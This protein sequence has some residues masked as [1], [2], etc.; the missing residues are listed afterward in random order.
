MA[1]QAVLIINKI[2]LDW[3]RK[4]F[5]ED[6]IFLARY[7]CL[8]NENIH[9]FCC[10]KEF[11][12]ELKHLSFLAIHWH[13]NRQGHDLLFT[14][15]IS[16]GPVITRRVIVLFGIY[17][18]IYN[19]IK[20]WL[21]KV[22]FLYVSLDETKAFC[23]VAKVFGHRIRW[24]SSSAIN[25]KAKNVVLKKPFSAED[26]PWL[27]LD[28]LP[29]IHP[30]SKIARLAQ[31]FFLPLARR[32]KHLYL[33]DWTS[34]DLAKKRKDTL[35]LN[36]KLPWKA[37]YFNNPKKFQKEGERV[38][39]KEVL[40]PCVNVQHIREVLSRKNIQW[41]EQLI[42]FFMSFVET[43]Y[44]DNR[45]IIIKAYSMYKDLIETYKPK[46][47]SI[48]GG[49]QFA[50]VIACQIARQSGAQTLL[51]IDGYQPVDD[52]SV[53]YLDET[54]KNFLW[55]DFAAYGQANLELLVSQG[56]DKNRC[57]LMEPTIINIHKRLKPQPKKYEAIVMGY[58]PYTINPQSHQTPERFILDAIK[59]LFDIGKRKIAVKIKPGNKFMQ[60]W[61]VQDLLLKHFKQKLNIDIL[62][63]EFYEH[64]QKAECVI[65]QGT[66]A[67]IETFFHDIPFYIYEPYENGMTDETINS[68]KI[69]NLETVARTPEELKEMIV[70]RKKSVQ[71]EK[72]Y[73]FSGPEFSK[74][75]LSKFWEKI[76]E[77]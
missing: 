62:T 42:K 54:G 7:Y 13:R 17:V 41:D 21:S 5:P 27:T 22:D 40:K 4:K 9:Y 71:V 2:D 73:V 52:E 14:N 64:V 32:R 3:L 65:G 66:T 25:E 50:Y 75:D 19:T 58:V 33:S 76:N 77:K 16:I 48:P 59:V 68:S 26:Y 37:Y 47:V 69:F 45:D 56:V 28:G 43:T 55:T 51:A 70:T 20:Y 18:R 60:D 8:E 1:K 61:E 74:A 30:L 34:R 49:T 31:I 63:G 67:V 72:K 23:E 38:F 29:Y 10:P 39:P 44:T 46:L 11:S 24:Y 36:S 15:G 53:M 6:T 35:I 12:T 57:V